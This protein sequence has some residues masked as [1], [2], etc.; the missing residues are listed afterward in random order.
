MHVVLGS[1][2]EIALRNHRG[3]KIPLHICV[4]EIAQSKK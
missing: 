1:C 3:L 2:I 4:A